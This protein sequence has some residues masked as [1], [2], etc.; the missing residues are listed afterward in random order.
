MNRMD[1]AAD[2]FGLK[3]EEEFLIQFPNRA[4]AM[5]PFKMMDGGLFANI[6]K[7]GWA[8]ANPKILE[9]LFTGECKVKKL[10]KK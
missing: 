5:G 9:Y 1:R 7:A 3:L 2:A 4:M 10:R 6:G 8:K